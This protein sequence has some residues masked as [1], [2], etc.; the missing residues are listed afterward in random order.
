[1]TGDTVECYNCGRA[2]PAWAQ[3]CRSCGVPLR[4]GSASLANAGPIPRDRDSLISIGAGLAAILGAV[5][6][7]LILS[8]M[9]PDAGAVPEKTATPSPTP[10]ASAL[11]SLEESLAP[12]VEP[13]PVPTP[14]LIG[15]V[16][17][18]TGIDSSTRQ[19]T[20]QTDTFGSGSA[21][22]H[23]VALTEPFG[24]TSIQEEVVK[25]Q[26]DGSLTVVQ[27]RAGSNLKVNPNTQI[28]GFCAPDTRA[29]INGWGEGDF[30]LRDYRNPDTPELI[31][32]GSFTLAR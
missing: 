17:F 4:P 15:T 20:G 29:L 7:G 12:S 32:E 8:G 28:A 3:V 10:S 22:C 6:V 24:V 13:T 2:N 19:A 21:F 5:I 1:M 25:V 26:A 23:S 30:I 18:G 31:A 16:T 14:A 27:P 9:I 11:P